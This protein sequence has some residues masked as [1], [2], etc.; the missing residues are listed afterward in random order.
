MSKNEQENTKQYKI[1]SQKNLDSGDLEMEIEISVDSLKKHREGAVKD[2][3]LVTEIPGFRKGSAPEKMIVEKVGEMAVLEKTA[4]RAINDILPFIIIDEKINALTQPSIS[5]TKI[6]I[7]SPL[8]MKATFTLMPEVKLPDYKKIAKEVDAK[9]DVEVDDKEVDD[10]IENIR[11]SKAV[12]P[13]KKEGENSE[14]KSEPILPELNDEFVQSVSPFKTVDELKEGLKKNIKEDKE[15][16]ESQR[17]RLE[18]MEKIIDGSDIKVPQILIDQELNRMLGEFKSRIES[19]KMNFEEYL[20]HLKKTE[21]ELKAEWIEDAK[22]RTKMNLIL[23]KIGAEENLKADEKEVE[24]EVAHLV[25]HHPDIDKEHAKVYVTNV[26]SNEEV[27]KFLE[28][29]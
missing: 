12:A 23:P 28:Q 20:T 27:F 3:S 16:K 8:E 11:K 13:E 2:I 9:K 18:I 29:I 15:Q 17:R 10:Y 24:K 1:I 19:M 5:I 14:E 4:Y 21:D 22:K 26:L 25:E 6:A 7:D